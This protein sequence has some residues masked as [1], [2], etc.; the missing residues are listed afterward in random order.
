[1]KRRYKYP[2]LILGG[3]WIVAVLAMT[4]RLVRVYRETK[5]ALQDVSDYSDHVVGRQY[6]Q[7]Y[8]Y[9]SSGFRAALSYDQFVTL[10]QRLERQYGTLK[11]VARQGYEVH[12]FG[13]PMVWKAVVDEDF[14]YEKKT[15]RFEFV[16]HK[17]DG[18]WAIFSVEQL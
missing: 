8:R 4:P 6:D 10:Y 18:H 12:G 9:S 16:L 13:D 1:M 11:S 17:E 15:L 5:I 7:A 2:L 14:V 3:L